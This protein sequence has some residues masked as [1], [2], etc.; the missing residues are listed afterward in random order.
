VN[1]LVKKQ[2][3]LDALTGLKDPHTGKDIV[4]EGCIENLSVR[5]GTVS[6]VMRAP[7]GECHC[8][9]YVPLVIDA[10]RAVMVLPGVKAVKMTFT[11]H[12]QEKAVNE[13]LKMLDEHIGN[14]KKGGSKR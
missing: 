13:A 10:K 6:F 11:G 14:A 3:V 12:L 1:R 7:E 9:Q 8:P 4:T 5:G 2:E